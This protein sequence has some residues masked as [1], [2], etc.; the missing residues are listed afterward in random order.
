MTQ[1]C[2]VMT[3]TQ[4]QGWWNVRG[5]VWRRDGWRDDC[6]QVTHDIVTCH[7]VASG[8]SLDTSQPPATTPL[9][10]ATQLLPTNPV[11]CR[12]LSLECK[13]IPKCAYVICEQTLTCVHT[14]DQHTKF[15]NNNT[16]WTS[17]SALLTRIWTSSDCGLLV[18]G[19]GRDVSARTQK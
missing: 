12:L 15:L 16:I 6:C 13:E 2:D 9:S 10:P 7:K 18:C 8:H 1:L 3:V 11:D 5:S 14:Y 19:G 4:M 17:R